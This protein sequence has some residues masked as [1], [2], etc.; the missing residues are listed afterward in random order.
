MLYSCI[1]T[2]QG[3]V[4]CLHVYTLI[5]YSVIENVY[6]NN[7]YNRNTNS[8]QNSIIQQDQN[9]EY[10]I[11][12]NFIQNQVAT[13]IHSFNESNSVY[14]YDTN[15]LLQTINLYRIRYYVLNAQDQDM[16]CKAYRLEQQ[17]VT[18]LWIQNWNLE[19]C[20]DIAFRS[21]LQIK[22][23]CDWVITSCRIHVFDFLF[24]SSLNENS[25]Q[26]D[27]KVYSR[28]PT[29]KPTNF[30]YTSIPS[31]LSIQVQLTNYGWFLIWIA[32]A[33]W[34]IFSYPWNF[35]LSHTRQKEIVLVLL[36]AGC[37]C[38]IHLIQL[39]SINAWNLWFLLLEFILEAIGYCRVRSQSN[40]FQSP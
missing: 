9:D 29:I 3:L 33:I 36:F 12:Q 34:F 10:G 1:R 16:R 15:L 14:I 13:T 7:F 19:L 22:I 40:S 6:F 17:T 38:Q 2:L 5:Q 20:P 28:S 27:E 23:I 24:S 4:L 35:R 39:L 30:I 25:I 26:I 32:Y 18:H 8:T 37:I 11:H 31:Q 21:S